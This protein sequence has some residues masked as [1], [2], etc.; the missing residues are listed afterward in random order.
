VGFEPTIPEFERAKTFRATDRAPSVFG[1]H[2]QLL[3]LNVRG[4][5]FLLP[6]ED[7]WKTVEVVFEAV[8]KET[9]C[10]SI[11]EMIMEMMFYIII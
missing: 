9:Y 2:Q 4:L 7:R 5:C 1:T 3:Q 10:D 8:N 6:Y 11:V